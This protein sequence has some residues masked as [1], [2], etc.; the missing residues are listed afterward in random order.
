MNYEFLPEA[1]TEFE[2][3]VAHYDQCGLGLGDEFTDEVEAVIARILNQPATWSVYHSGTRRCLTRRFPYGVVY[4]IRSN[5]VLIV[6]IAHLR[7]EPGYWVAR[8]TKPQ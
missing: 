2:Q 5:R 3:A 6:A 4:Q 7:R 8:V 1:R